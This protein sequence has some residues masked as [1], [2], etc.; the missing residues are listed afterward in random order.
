MRYLLERREKVAYA[1]FRAAGCDVGSGPTESMCKSLS[2]RM[3]GIAMR[4][5]GN[6]AQ[7]MVALESLQQS[8]LWPNYWSNQIAA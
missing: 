7:A 4:W 2:R 8:N 1:G 3:K 6:N 5:T